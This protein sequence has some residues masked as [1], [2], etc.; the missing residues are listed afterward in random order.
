[1]NAHRAGWWTVGLVLLACSPARASAPDA[2]PFELSLPD[3]P[4][5]AVA[6]ELTG[7]LRAGIDAAADLQVTAPP[8][9]VVI[10]AGD[11]LPAAI[12]LRLGDAKLP[13]PPKL[14]R[15][16]REALAAFYA[17]GRFQP[18][19]IEAGSWSDRARSIADTLARADQDGL[20]PADYPVP[21]LDRPGGAQDAADLA[22]A[23]LKLSAAAFL[24]ARDARGGRIEPS[25]L[26]GMMTPKL[27]LP[28]VEAVLAALAG[29]ASP[30]DVLAGFHPAYPGYRALK[31]KLA[32]I[33][34]DRPSG[35]VGRLSGGTG[36]ARQAFTEVGGDPAP[37]RLPRIAPARLE[38][39]IVANMERWRW[40][41][42]EAGPRYILVNVPE[43]RLRLVEDG[44]VSHEAR[45]IVGKPDTPTPIFT[46]RMAYAVV[47]PS[48]FVPPSILKKQLA[49]G[50]S[51]KG[52]VV[53][54]RGKTVTMRQ[55]PGPTNALGYIKLMFPNDHAVYLHD[56]PSRHLFGAAN[57]ALSH[58]CVRVEQPF[59]LAGKIMGPAWTEERL[60]K[61]IGWGERYIN[62]AEPLPVNLA[63]FTV[64][65]DAFG[66]IRTFGDVYGH[67]RR[68]RVALGLGA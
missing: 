60:K 31:A 46:G 9:P 25:R 57:R 33:R 2:R 50:G 23:E 26:S 18:L 28:A 42:A 40:L 12:Q 39:D 61:L 62:L 55:P 54:Q 20:D 34:A 51:T 1:M 8:A 64:T 27:D 22:E 21:R 68:V 11:I 17:A 29:S 53:T 37:A 66:E 13:L 14:A 30:A 63:Y 41:P 5:A 52:F 4:A 47:N 59:A 58:G 19:W 45:V 43:L 15:K 3:L 56:T 16:D 48:W 32:E 10:T 44:A 49:A 65:V 38:G 36:L 7:R 67:H 6:V 35:P 24:Y